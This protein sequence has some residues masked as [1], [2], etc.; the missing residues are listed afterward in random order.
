MLRSSWPWNDL[1]GDVGVVADDAAG[2]STALVL[3]SVPV[4]LTVL[5][6]PLAF[7]SLVSGPGLGNKIFGS[8]CL[9]CARILDGL[10]VNTKT[11]S[12]DA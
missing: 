9:C 1:V 7:C 6:A 4:G 2:H 12:I 5:I 3:P 10:R 8:F 11:F